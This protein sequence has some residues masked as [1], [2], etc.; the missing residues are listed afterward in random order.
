MDWQTWFKWHED[1]P[2]MLVNNQCVIV[3]DMYQAFKARLIVETT[4]E[5]WPN[6]DCIGVEGN[7]G[8]TEGE[9][10]AAPS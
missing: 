4:M 5:K 8:K 2:V 7:V 9:K 6:L 10:W 1:R 3:E